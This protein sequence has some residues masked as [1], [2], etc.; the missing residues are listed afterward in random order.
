VLLLVV[1]LLLVLPLPPL[2]LRPL[3]RAAALPGPAGAC[4]KS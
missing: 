4:R 1:L 3:P 2:L